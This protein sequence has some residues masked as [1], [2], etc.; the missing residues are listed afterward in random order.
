MTGPLFRMEHVGRVFVGDFFAC[1]AKATEWF[2]GLTVTLV[3]EELPELS[4]EDRA[5]MG[6]ALTA[7]LSD[8]ED[9][10]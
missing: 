1:A 5:A 2:P 6:E 9:P 8:L 4:P 3:A 7:I 10:Q